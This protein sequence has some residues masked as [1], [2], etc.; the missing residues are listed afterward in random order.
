MTADSTDNPPAG[1]GPERV[2]V[3]TRLRGWLSTTETEFSFIKGLTFISFVGTLIG[4]YFHYLS[5]YQTKVAT[6][7][8]E[9]LLA[10]TQAF[11][12]TSGTLSRAIMLQADLFHDFEAAVLDQRPNGE[13]NDLASKNAAEIFKAYEAEYSGLRQNI[14]LLARKAEIYLDWPS[15]LDRDR[16]PLSMISNDPLSTSVLGAYEFDCDSAMPAFED[17]R[18]KHPMHH[19]TNGS[20]LEVNWLKAKHHVLTIGY[21]F[22]ATHVGYMGVIRQW[23]SRGSV[24]PNDRAAFLEKRKNQRDLLQDR[25]DSEV[26]RLNTFMI[27][28]MD[29]MDRIGRR[30]RQDSF[31]CY[32]PGVG[33][34]TK[35]CRL[36]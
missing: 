31:L 7:A 29:E 17:G 21:C 18:S 12:E 36:I 23:A 13:P 24:S 22:Y 28:G 20:T 5:D 3:L 19:P 4:G 27:L 2:G 33:W 16:P 26:V 8:K 6:Q 14:S 30:Y 15:T 1:H 25:L 9:D 35:K 32:L 10:A 34:V 11:T